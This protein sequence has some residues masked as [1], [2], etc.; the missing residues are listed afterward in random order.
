MEAFIVLLKVLWEIF[1]IMKTLN[2]LFN[3]LYI[4]IVLIFP[5]CIHAQDSFSRW[6]RCYVEGQDSIDTN[7]VFRTY[8]VPKD[9]PYLEEHS[10]FNV[11]V[12]HSYIGLYTD[13]NVWGKCVTFASFDFENGKEVEIEIAFK[14][15]INS[16]EVLPGNAIFTNIQQS[17]ANSISLK[18]KKT[19]QP[20]TFVINGKYQGDVLHLF[21][22]SIDSMVPLVSDS[23]GYIYDSKQE[24]YYFGP[25]FHKL[26]N[27]FPNGTLSIS[28]NQ[29]IYVS[30]GAV[31]EGQLR[32]N[33]GK[34][35][36]IYGRGMVMNA[37]PEI[38]L[39]IDNSLGSCNVEGIIIHGHRAQCWCTTMSKSSNVNFSNI[40][41]LT[42][43]YA[44]T[45]GIDIINCS[46]CE[47]DNV[48][49]RSC[50][51]AIA[52]K[53]LAP[54][55]QDPADCLPNKNLIFRKMQLWNDCNNAFGIGAETRASVYENIQLLDSE[56]LYSYD[57]PHHH[58]ELDERSAMNIC[59]LQGT[60]FK[61]I[62]F[63]N[64][65]VNRCE[66]L[67]GMGFKNDFWFGSIQGNQSYNGGIDNVIFRNITCEKNSGSS[68][69]NEIWLYGWQ[70]EGTPQ[71]KLTNIFFDNVRIEGHLLK[72]DHY[73]GFRTNNV[74]GNTLVNYRFINT[75]LNQ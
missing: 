73:S 55:T 67:I 28:G 26:A 1:K 75:H 9:Y 32:V 38:V 65:R 71:K 35:V 13:K 5:G 48:F 36:K 21:C 50:D 40:K 2:L 20:L 37:K 60:Y 72:D 46:D 14:D 57:D 39:S 17:S 53:G 56:V 22:N 12:N 49:V 52:I 66:R 29:K 34:G 15:S 54:K 16:F 62:L 30:G 42:T 27:Y 4:S 19:D 63:Q 8:S 58:T 45:D 74:T 69:A 6:N 61:N 59:A 41:V 64:I 44:S 3:V 11:Y 24:L 43:R 33:N 10:P 25:G 47:F 68:I 7:N 51:D 31:L 18:L 70:K 23:S